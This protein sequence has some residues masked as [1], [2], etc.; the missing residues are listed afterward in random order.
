M[1][2]CETRSLPS[3]LLR[4]DCDDLQSCYSPG[5][6]AGVAG[7]WALMC[8]QKTTG[9][10]GLSKEASPLG[11]VAPAAGSVLPDVAAIVVFYLLHTVLMAYVLL[12]VFFDAKNGF[13]AEKPAQAAIFIVAIV[14]VLG[15][16][17][18]HWRLIRRR[19]RAECFHAFTQNHWLGLTW[20]VAVC[21][22]CVFV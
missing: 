15:Q 20:F 8:Q 18:W 5:A 22:L 13:Q 12:S 3:R 1:E 7:S 11:P 10:R 4:G 2:R 17:V 19:E 9:R 6:E 16:I 21:L 14:A